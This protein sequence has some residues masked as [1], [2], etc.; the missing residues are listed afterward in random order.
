MKNLFKFLDIIFALVIIILIVLVLYINF[1]IKQFPVS[2]LI[3]T[4]LFLF[5]SAIFLIIN[6]KEN[7]YSF[8]KI[9]KGGTK[10]SEL[11]TLIVGIMFG[12]CALY[13]A[14]FDKNASSKFRAISVFVALFLIGGALF[15]FASNRKKKIKEQVGRDDN[16][17]NGHPL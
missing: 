17:K 10:T 16:I 5:S 4:L 13:T 12:T 7:R 3:M 9:L 1:F 14:F 8:S 11:L 6:I 2:L 15:N